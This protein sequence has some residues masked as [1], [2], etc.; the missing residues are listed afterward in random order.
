MTN[1]PVLVTFLKASPG[2]QQICFKMPSTPASNT[3]DHLTGYGCPTIAQLLL[4]YK[5]QR[6]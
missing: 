6:L 2:G 3:G 1:F 4:N 5:Y